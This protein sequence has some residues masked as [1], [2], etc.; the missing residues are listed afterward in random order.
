[1]VRSLPDAS[2]YVYATN[3]APDGSFTVT[4]SQ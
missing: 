1:M 4:K 2:K 3:T